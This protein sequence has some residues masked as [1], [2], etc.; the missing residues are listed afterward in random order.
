[1]ANLTTRELAALEDQ[2]SFEQTLVKKYRTMAEQCG[3][4]RL[5]ND[6]RTYA[7][8][9]QQHYNMLLTFLQ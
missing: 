6:F 5:K 2:L 3:D 8:K 9:H 1:M 4:V 7:D